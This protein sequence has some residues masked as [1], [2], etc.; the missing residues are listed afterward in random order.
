MRM[1]EAVARC[2]RRFSPDWMSSNRPI[3]SDVEVVVVVRDRDT[4]TDPP[5]TS[6]ADADDV[7]L[8]V[9]PTSRSTFVVVMLP[10]PM[11]LVLQVILDGGVTAAGLNASAT[12]DDARRTQQPTKTAMRL[13][14][15]V[16]VRS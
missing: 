4:V 6:T 16:I 10:L 5:C 3:R 15:V 12:P 9:V 14:M 1:C 13:R 2:V 7:L 8:H 11:R